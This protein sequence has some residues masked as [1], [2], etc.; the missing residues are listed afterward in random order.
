MFRR[1]HCHKRS[2]QRAAHLMYEFEANT[3]DHLLDLNK[4]GMKMKQKQQQ[5]GLRPM[6]CYEQGVNSMKHNQEFNKRISKSVTKVETKVKHVKRGSMDI[7][8]TSGRDNEDRET[9]GQDTFDIDVIDPL[10]TAN[11]VNIFV[12]PNKSMKSNQKKYSKISKSESIGTFLPPAVASRLLND[13]NK[14]QQRQVVPETKLILAGS[15]ILSNTSFEKK[16]SPEDTNF[17]VVDYQIRNAMIP[18]DSGHNT[19]ISPMN[20]FEQISQ[21]HDPYH[22]PNISLISF[23][24]MSSSQNTFNPILPSSSYDHTRNQICQ[25]HNSILPLDSFDQMNPRAHSSTY[26]SKSFHL[27]NQ[28]RQNQNNINH[29][30]VLANPFDQFNQTSIFS[31]NV[32]RTIVHNSNKTQNI[33]SPTS[34]FD[35]TGEPN[36]NSCI[37]NIAFRANPFDQS[38]HDL[39]SFDSHSSHLSAQ[40]LN[41]GQDPFSTVLHQQNT[42]YKNLY[43]RKSET[44]SRDTLCIWD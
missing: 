12:P 18:S 40:N 22:H 42:D 2:K 23:D 15:N 36:Q 25:A 28:D 19:I 13:K 24:Q 16:S 1:V 6:I 9:P 5:V 38:N 31:G 14:M 10:D 44:Q 7:E 34:S 30:D 17:G 32:S 41:R 37:Q 20:S 43:S 27:M 3:D 4:E 11:A 21:G 33:I 35:Q 8:I 29:N 26:S 39:L